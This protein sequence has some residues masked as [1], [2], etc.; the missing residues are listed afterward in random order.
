[1]LFYELADIIVWRLPLCFL[2][3]CNNQQDFW[4]S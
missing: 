1:V 2:H 3:T 4:Q